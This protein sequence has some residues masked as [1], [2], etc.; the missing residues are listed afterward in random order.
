M[1]GSFVG[2]VFQPN[3]GNQEHYL[4]QKSVHFAD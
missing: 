4:R 1:A 2:L 3:K